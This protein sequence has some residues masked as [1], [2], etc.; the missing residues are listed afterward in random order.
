LASGVKALVVVGCYLW[1]LDSEV[2]ARRD[3]EPPLEEVQRRYWYREWMEHPDEQ[4]VKEERELENEW[5]S[6]LQ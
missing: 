2:L 6:H 1:S 3:R 5:R 4:L